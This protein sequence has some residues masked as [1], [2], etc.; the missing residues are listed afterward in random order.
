MSN[1]IK[2]T[3]EVD[4]HQT[5]VIKPLGE[6]LSETAKAVKHPEERDLSTTIPTTYTTDTPFTD[7]GVDAGIDW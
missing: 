1:K 6:K 2:I 7:G 3:L 4:P 5:V